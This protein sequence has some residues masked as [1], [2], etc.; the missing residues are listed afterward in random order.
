MNDTTSYADK[1]PPSLNNVLKS[2]TGFECLMVR[3]IKDKN[4][5]KNKSGNCHLNVKAY[6]DKFGGESVSGWLLY[7]NPLHSDRGMYVW[8]FHSV[9]KKPDGKWLD[10]TEDKNYIGRDKSIFIPDIKRKP[11][12]YEGISFNNIL[13][14]VE[15]KFA[16]YYG[17]SIGYQILANC[18]Y[19]TDTVMLRVI[20]ENEHSGIYRLLSPEYPNNH[21]MMCDEYELE[22]V[23]GK[24]VPISG[25]RYELSNGFP[26]KMLFDFSV[27]SRG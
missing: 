16:L 13:I 9:W 23:N 7:R 17:N 1:L 25:S 26:S 27:S 3:K 21:K 24:P 20:K 18:V 12:L 5:L 6:V 14:I 2:F 4:Q 10:V 8:S 19:W 22:I 11:D 15:P